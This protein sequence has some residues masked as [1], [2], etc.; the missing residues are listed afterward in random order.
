MKVEY[1]SQL[2]LYL[3]KKLNP[4]LLLLCSYAVPYNFI[5]LDNVMCVEWCDGD[6][7]C[8]DVSLR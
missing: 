5:A 4:E 3:R 8:A 7:F 6:E 1:Y 2:R